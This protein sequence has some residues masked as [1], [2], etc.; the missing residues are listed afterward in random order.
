MARLNKIRTDEQYTIGRSIHGGVDKKIRL[1]LND[2]LK[3]RKEEKNID[4]K[5][6]IAILSGA[7]AITAVIIAIF[8]L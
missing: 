1:N 3:K 7:T 6:N 8:G 5:V 4:R 2:L